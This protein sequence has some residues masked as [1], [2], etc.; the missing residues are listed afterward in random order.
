VTFDA[1]RLATG[2]YLYQIRSGKFIETKR[3]LLVK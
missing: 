1:S 3:M 2:M